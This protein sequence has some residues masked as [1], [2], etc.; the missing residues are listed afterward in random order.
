VHT[1]TGGELSSCKSDPSFD[2][3][4]DYEC[5]FDPNYVVK[6]EVLLASPIFPHALLER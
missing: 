4:E 5:N 1:V 2:V 3:F 6:L